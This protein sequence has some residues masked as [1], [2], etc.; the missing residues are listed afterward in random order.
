MLNHKGN[1]SGTI[2]PLLSHKERPLRK[3][4]IRKSNFV[5]VDKDTCR[6]CHKT[7]HYQKDCP[8]L[9]PLYLNYAKSTWWID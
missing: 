2:A 3:I 1:L 4:T 9:L 6:W 5:Q 8:E 7:R